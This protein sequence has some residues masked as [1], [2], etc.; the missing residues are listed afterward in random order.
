LDAVMR[1]INADLESDIKKLSADVQVSELG[2][3][4]GDERLLRQVLLNLVANSLKFV[5]SEHPR[6]RIE[7]K[8]RP[9]EVLIR[10]TDRGIGIPG[11]FVD[12]VFEPFRR[13]HSPSEFPGSGVGLS[14]CRRIIERHG[15]EIWVES[16]SGRGSVFSFTIPE[17]L[18]PATIDVIPQRGSGTSPEDSGRDVQSTDISS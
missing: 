9:S 6:I 5:E 12:V 13:L 1:D 11:D 17:V 18:D 8:D 10:V 4:Q 14:V 16:N 15:G 2:T 7:R 3:V